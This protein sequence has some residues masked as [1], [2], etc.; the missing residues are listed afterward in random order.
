MPPGSAMSMGMMAPSDPRGQPIHP[1]GVG[2]PRAGSAV[3]GAGLGG[4]HPGQPLQ[5]N[6]PAPMEGYNKGSLKALVGRDGVINWDRYA[7]HQKFEMSRRAEERE[8]AAALAMTR[9]EEVPQYD[10]PE[11]MMEELKSLLHEPLMPASF[12]GLKEQSLCT[13][14]RRPNS[15][16]DWE[17]AE[18]V[19]HRLHPKEGMVTVQ[20]LPDQHR[21]I[22]PV[23]CVQ[24][25]LNITPEYPV[26]WLR[27]GQQLPTAHQLQEE[28]KQHAELLAM[29]YP[30]PEEYTGPLKNE[31]G[32][33]Y[34]KA[35]FWGIPVTTHEALLNRS[36]PL[37][38]IRTEYGPHFYTNLYK[39]NF[40]L[41]KDVAVSATGHVGLKSEGGLRIAD[42]ASQW[43]AGHSMDGVT[44]GGGREGEAGAGGREGEARWGGCEGE[45]RGIQ[46]AIQG[47]QG[48][49]FSE[50]P[51]FAAS[52]KRAGLVFDQAI[53]E[54][55]LGVGQA[56]N[57]PNLAVFG[58]PDEGAHLKSRVKDRQIVKHLYIPLEGPKLEEDA[59]GNWHVYH[60]E[61]EFH[62]K[63]HEHQV[64]REKNASWMDRM[65]S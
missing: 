5:P 29:G 39:N 61:Q 54:R 47:A 18:A 28:M 25:V 24:P 45:A 7:E 50:N 32:S 62:D 31:D 52:A 23:A 27:H 2:T 60:D 44:G 22:V 58:D 48:A 33:Y 8:R 36:L 59:K 17:L 4:I 56:S 14:W 57:A 13:T 63:V 43:T 40:Y 51:Q 9:G 41:E 16:S 46:G 20:F 6:P 1:G 53:N 30:L 10:T 42:I 21:A 37:S 11:Q 49:G 19:I 35:E 34:A 55:G 64:A 26:R 3:P 38:Q 65:F 12:T 15:W